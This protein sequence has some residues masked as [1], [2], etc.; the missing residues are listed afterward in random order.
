MPQPHDIS[1]DAETLKRTFRE[2][3]SIL[4]VAGETSADR[5]GAN[6]V[7]KIRALC[8][9]RPL[10]FFG[11]GGDEMRQAG[12]EVL[13]HNR[14][15]ASIGPREAIQHL[16][17][18]FRTYRL[19]LHTCRNRNA[20]VAVLLDF[21]DFN[22][23]MARSLKRLGVKVIYYISPQIWAWR[24]WR[25]RSVRRHVDRMLVIL[26]FEEEY[27]RVRGVNVDFVGHPI[28][29]DFSIQYDREGFL[30]RHGLDAGLKTVAILPGSRRREVDYILP[31]LLEASQCL[32][33]H[34]P[35]QFL[36]S[37][38]PAV[39]G[40]HVR[41]IASRILG[42]SLDGGRFRI[43][44][45]EARTILAHSDFGFVKSGTSTLEAALTGTPFVIAYKISPAS[46]ALGNILIRSPYKG[47]VNLI[48][49]EEIVPEL[50]QG[51]ATP[52]ALAGVA[53]EYLGDPEKAMSMKA[54]LGGIREHLGSRC[55]S[56]TAAA[57]VV[58]YLQRRVM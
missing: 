15:L 1:G 25:I 28:L 26:P 11:V 20:A 32:L 34:I 8:G 2:S 47:L 58:K 10:H 57:I 9:G 17:R 39:D 46:W 56:D 48:A 52:E 23:R 37:R 40:R 22:L 54:R 43:L 53:R 14:N 41:E 13:C 6:L 4:M 49:G 27:Y 45:V 33:R 42:S 18:Y 16:Y 51:Q 50:L 12:V 5:Y 44:S 31:A 30:H 35:A 38:A 29:E 19:L 7:R 36:I 3:E 55:A 24:R 21:P